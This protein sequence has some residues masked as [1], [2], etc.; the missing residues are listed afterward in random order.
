MCHQ[1]GMFAKVWTD[2]QE[3]SAPDNYGV[4]SC[5]SVIQFEW[6]SANGVIQLVISPDGTTFISSITYTG[7]AN[8]PGI[9]YC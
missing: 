6:D 9:Y 3:D 8:V 1:S 7:T 5:E 4:F 2:V